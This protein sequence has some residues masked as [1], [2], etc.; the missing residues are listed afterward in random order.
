M[1]HRPLRCRSV[2][3]G[4]VLSVAAALPGLAREDGASSHRPREVAGVMLAGAA[5]RAVAVTVRDASGRLLE[6]SAPAVEVLRPSAWSPGD[7]EREGACEFEV[8]LVAARLVRSHRLAGLIS[9]CDDRGTALPPA[10][11]ALQRAAA[12]GVPVV[13]VGPVDAW[14][15]HP[16]GVFV[17]AHGLSPEEA[18]R[19]L[20]ECLLTF[21]ALPPARNPLA[22]SPAEVLAL[23]AQVARYQ[24]HF[25]AQAGVRVAAR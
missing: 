16:A 15:A 20:R 12:M 19:L 24:Q 23:R 5:T 11:R 8:L 25:E 3:L 22:P 9:V 13:R 7:P 2:L 17:N 6:E 14:V 4:A 1:S 10:E 18:S 21:G